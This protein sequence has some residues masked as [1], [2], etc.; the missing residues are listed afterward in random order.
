LEETKESEDLAALGQRDAQEYLERHG[1]IRHEDLLLPKQDAGSPTFIGADLTGWEAET[2]LIDPR[3]P[4]QRRAPKGHRG[5]PPYGTKMVKNGCHALEAMYGLDRL[6]LLTL[7]LP[8]H[9]TYLPLWCEQWAEILRKFNQE[10]QRELDR[11]GAPSHLIGV[12]EIQTKRSDRE[13][14]CIPHLHV[15]MVAWD[16]KSYQPR[17]KG[18]KRLR[19]KIFYLSHREIQSIFQRVLLNEVR[20]I[21]ETE[22]E[23]EGTKPRISIEAIKKTA[24]GY[25]GKYLSKGAKDV[26][27]YLDADPNRTDIPSHW[28]HCTK[29]LRTIIKGLIVPVAPAMIEAITT[30]YGELIK[31]GLVQYLRPIDI[32]IGGEIRT[33]AYA[34][35]WKQKF[36]P[37]GKDQVRLA[38]S[39]S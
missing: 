6:G 10:L 3:Q 28:W 26:K 2:K 20:R 17:A 15:V 23:V 38:F 37:I 21:T 1:A 12:T 35:R 30:N 34:G 33:I 18:A 25:L 24:E 5:I 11:R 31:A 8:S 14:Y 19:K 22:P 27:K 16:G 9:P 36:N 39:T 32:A 29:A 7:T 4:F 13:G